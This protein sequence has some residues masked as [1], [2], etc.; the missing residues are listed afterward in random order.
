MSQSTLE[1][2]EHSVETTN[3]WLDELAAELGSGDRSEAYRVLGAVLHAL[4]DRIGPS[5]SAHLAAQLPPLIRGVFYEDWVP[6]R[7]PEHYC[8]G[9]AFLWRVARDAH[10][11]GE[12]EASFAVS[13][14]A[15]VLNR[16]LSVGELGDV[17]T[18]LP[19][20]V[21]AVIAG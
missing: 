9:E 18:V 11:H 10:L 17:L 20:H 8:D 13:A 21:R 14:V 6:S 12:T 3:V 19:P 7:T 4:R 16:H 5:E 15:T 2:V 1:S